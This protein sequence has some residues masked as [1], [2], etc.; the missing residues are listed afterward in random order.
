[1]RC[2]IREAYQADQQVDCMEYRPSP[3]V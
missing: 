1:M 3:P 2:V